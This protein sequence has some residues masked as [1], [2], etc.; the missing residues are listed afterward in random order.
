M[1]FV[2]EFNQTKKKM[3][4]FIRSN[5]FGLKRPKNMSTSDWRSLSKFVLSEKED[6]Q[7]QQLSG[8]HSS[9]LDALCNLIVEYGL[10]LNSIAHVSKI[11]N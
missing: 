2:D 9:K 1:N 5:F 10:P 7:L 4:K 11:S 3:L 8:K 6:I